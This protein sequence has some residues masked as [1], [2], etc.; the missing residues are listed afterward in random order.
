MA[1][2]WLPSRAEEGSDDHRVISSIN[3]GGPALRTSLLDSD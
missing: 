2:P 3:A 1:L